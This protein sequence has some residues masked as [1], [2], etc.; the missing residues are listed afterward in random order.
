MQYNVLKG[1]GHGAAIDASE[2]GSELTRR[3]L[4][5]SRQQTLQNR[6]VGVNS[7]LH[8]MHGI[9][10]HAVGGTV[11]LAILP[12]DNLWPIRADATMLE[13]AI[14]NLCI[15]ARDAMKPK[16]G[17]LTI[18]TFNRTLDYVRERT[19]FG[20]PISSFQNTQFVLAECKTEATVARVF[21]NHCI[22]SH[23]QGKLD[24]ATASMAAAISVSAGG[25]I[26]AP[27]PR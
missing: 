18:E 8:K 9:L 16:G 4:A 17:N 1:K 12:A 25:T 5:F 24:A 19:A 7:L 23:L 11:N 21:V 10:G 20:S 13:T 26:W 15:N 27:S 3:M 14:L 2:K 6:E 22:A